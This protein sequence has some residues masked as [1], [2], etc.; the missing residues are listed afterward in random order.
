M[1]R[2]Y[3]LPW[4]WGQEI[5]ASGD[6]FGGLSPILLPMT[7]AGLGLIFSIAG[8]F[9]VKVKEGGSVQKALNM[10]NWSSI[11]FTVIASYFLVH[12]MLP[13]SMVHRGISFTNS[14]VFWS[15]FLGLIVGALMSI[16]TEYYTSMGKTPGKFNC[17][18]IVNRSRYQHHRRAF[19]WHGINPAA[20]YCAGSRYLRGL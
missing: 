19:R 20:Y 15:I 18:T 4:C 1:L 10:G 14:H 17:K 11:V 13:E 7:I 12:W 6:Q 3:W 9:M 2:P 8:T 16:I 5:D